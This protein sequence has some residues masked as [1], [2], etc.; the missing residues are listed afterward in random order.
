M[1][2]AFSFILVLGVLIFVHELGH[3]LFA[4]LFGVKV[5]KFSLGFGNKV[6]SRKWGETEYLISAFPLGGY[7][8]MYGEHTGDDVDPS[9]EAR[10]FAHKSVWQ[11]FGI[12]FGGPLFNILFAIFLFFAIFS[13]SGLPEAVDNTIIGEVTENSAAQKAGLQKGDIILAINDQETF[14]WRDVSSL[15]KESGGNSIA[16]EIEREGEPLNISAQPEKQKA[17]NLFGEEVGEVRYMLGIVRSDDKIVYEKVPFVEAGRAAL[18]QTWNLSY[19]TIMGI[20]KMIQ[21]VIPASELGGPIRI[22]EIAGQQMEAGWMNLMYF[23]GLLS[24]NL[25][26]LNLLPVPVLDGGHLIFLSLEAVRR[27]PLSDKTMEISQ[28][29][30]IALLGTLMVFVFYND[31]A[32]VVQRWLGS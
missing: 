20:V 28:K 19:L 15:I 8:K 1:N 32:R 10:S 27:K 21:R 11:R 24:I 25:G 13:F 31:I 3:F 29:T 5:L 2:S 12:V 30:G 7:V 22:A 23:M 4:K 9:L 17:K 6:I 18:I 14:S 26:I 16:L